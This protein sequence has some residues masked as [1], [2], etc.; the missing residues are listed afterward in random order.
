LK[1]KQGSATPDLEDTLCDR[2]DSLEVRV[3]GLRQTL[4]EIRTGHQESGVK[5]T[6][7]TQL[8]V[9]TMSTG[10]DYDLPSV[11]ISAA[12]AK[13]KEVEDGLARCRSLLSAYEKN[14]VRVQ[15]REEVET[16]VDMVSIMV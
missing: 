9:V 1:Q 7:S 5:S 6:L 15:R 13:M 3:P 4:A 10:L 2:L 11:S 12:T 14:S 8:G 16:R